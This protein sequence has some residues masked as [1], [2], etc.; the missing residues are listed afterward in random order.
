MGRMTAPHYLCPHTGPCIPVCNE[1]LLPLSH[2]GVNS[3]DGPW[4][5][6]HQGATVLEG[7]PSGVLLTSHLNWLTH[8]HFG[9]SLL[10][11]FTSTQGLFHHRG[12]EIKANKKVFLQ[13]RELWMDKLWKEN[14]FT[15]FLNTRETFNIATV[16]LEVLIVLLS[17]NRSC[18]NDGSW[19][20][21]WQADV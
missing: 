1:L 21:K 8:A 7:R 3:G 19:Q 15:V 2:C 17:G 20:S 5:L 12:H 16:R 13:A 9:L 14:M 6:L 18:D 4:T 10:L 11:E